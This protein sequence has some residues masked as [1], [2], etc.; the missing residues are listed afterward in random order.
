MSA[1]GR[2]WRRGPWTRWA[3]PAL[4]VLL[5]NASAAHAHEFWLQPGDYAA[6]SGQT[7]SLQFGVGM[8][9]QGEVRAIDASRIVRFGFIDAEGERQ[10]GAS[11]SIQ[12]RSPGP[13]WGVF[14]GNRAALTLDADAFE[15]YLRD[16]GLEH[17]IEVRKTRGEST[18]GGREVYS[19]CAKTL[20]QVGETKRDDGLVSNP[21]GL[22][23][24]LVPQNF[25]RVVSNGEPF[26]VQLLF[27]GKPLAGALVK[28][29]PKSGGTIF[30]TR[31][32][33]TGLAVLPHLTGGI[34]LL[35][36]VH[37][38]RAD[39]RLDADWESIWS[40]LTLRLP[41]VPQTKASQPISDRRAANPL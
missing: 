32:D 27:Q 24:E 26:R 33:G 2:D 14:R 35:N 41:E 3:G 8:G 16:E 4:A 19:R 17:V 12:T 9:W 31:T 22:T 5:L 7:M 28:A 18:Q 15:A 23:L 29:F 6:R 1:V 10:M 38:V 37:M 13:A 21:V 11:G 39:T 34:W 20:V 25:A 36:A 40:S 30:K